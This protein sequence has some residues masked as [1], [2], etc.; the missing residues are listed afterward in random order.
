M[1]IDHVTDKFDSMFHLQSMPGRVL[2]SPLHSAEDDQ[3][4]ISL[5]AGSLVLL[6]EKHKWASSQAN[7]G[8]NH[9]TNGRTLRKF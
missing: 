3:V 4:D 8:I 5:P 1:T 2:Y 9:T 6:C 7:Q